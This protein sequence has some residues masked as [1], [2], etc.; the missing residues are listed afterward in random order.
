MR[1]FL[2]APIKVSVSFGHGE[3]TIPWGKRWSISASIESL[4]PEAFSTRTGPNALMPHRFS[5]S[6]ISTGPDP[7]QK[8]DYLLSL[9]TATNCLNK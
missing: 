2:I 1:P 5:T 6:S 7:H 9:D 8:W 3:P 4:W